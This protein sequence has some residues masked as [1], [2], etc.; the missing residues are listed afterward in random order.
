MLSILGD[1]QAIGELR[2]ATQSVKSQLVDPPV[3]LPHAGVR[4]Q[5][6]ATLDRFKESTQA[7]TGEKVEI[8]GDD[9]V[10]LR[11]GRC[12]RHGEIGH[13]GAANRRT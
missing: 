1:A 4:R 7:E 6:D 5:R 3:R 12:G 8:F 10:H 2:A 13:E 9:L 11:G